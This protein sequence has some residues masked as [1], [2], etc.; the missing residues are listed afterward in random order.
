MMAPHLWRP[1]LRARCAGGSSNCSQHKATSAHWKTQM[2][3]LSLHW[4][5][6]ERMPGCNAV[7]SIISLY[8]R[9]ISAVPPP[10]LVCQSSEQHDHDA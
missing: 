4:P 6:L 7:L 9:Y 2:V 1:L 5:A 3:W 10:A 8:R